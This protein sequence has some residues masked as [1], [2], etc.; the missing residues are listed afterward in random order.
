MN[1]ADLLTYA[2]ID[3]LQRMASHYGCGHDLHS[4][5]DLISSLL[6]HLGGK[7]RLEGE[8]DT[9]SEAEFRFL[10][11]L[12]F[13]S[14]DL[15]SQEELLAKGRAALDGKKEEP[16]RL[17]RLACRKG[18]LFPGFSHRHKYLFR[19]PADLRRRY[20][21]LFADK[22]GEGGG[23]SP[24]AYR[25]EEG[26]LEE[27]LYR[28]LTFLYRH[29]VRLTSEGGIYRQQ[30]RQLFQTFQVREDPIDRKGW[31]FGFGRRYHLYPD[32]FSLLYDYAFFK[33]YIAEDEME[34]CLR[35]TE[36]GAGKVMDNEVGEGKELYRFW[37]RLYKKPIPQLAMIVKWVELLARE[38][39]Q[40]TDR[41]FEVASPWMA[42]YYYESEEDLFHRIMKMMLHLGLLRIGETGQSRVVRM[43]PTGRGWISGVAGFAE[44]TLDK[45]WSEPAPDQ[46][47]SRRAGDRPL[48]ME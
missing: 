31:R 19:M 20:L 30:Q 26:L 21:N 44:S 37:L 41:L 3:T 22:Y 6:H 17:V 28:F 13:D 9:L 16:R 18:W 43:N 11:Q 15:F 4:K 34:G 38:S 29:E 8:V 46:N 24:S 47:F 35:L 10:Q 2:D 33:G 32:R 7:S 23:P 40:E 14:R 48:G 36:A 27:D 39:W 25:S 12:C 5:N 45:R 1:F 42:S